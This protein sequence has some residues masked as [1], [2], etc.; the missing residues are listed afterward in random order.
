MQVPKSYEAISSPVALIRE[1]TFKRNL[2][3]EP[4]YTQEPSRIND[5]SK[6]K[7]NWKKSHYNKFPEIPKILEYD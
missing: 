1:N 4:K 3:F 2:N 6:T 5:L 7:V